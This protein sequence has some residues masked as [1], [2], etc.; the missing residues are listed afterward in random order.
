MQREKMILWTNTTSCA[1]RKAG[2]NGG[3]DGY[4]FANIT[5]AL[6]SRCLLVLLLSLAALHKVLGLQASLI[7]FCREIKLFIFN[8]FNKIKNPPNA[9]FS[10]QFIFLLISSKL[11][12]RLSG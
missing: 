6:S 3:G 11:P 4:S 9:I 12:S 2:G 8:D 7:C 5:L 1:S 10:S